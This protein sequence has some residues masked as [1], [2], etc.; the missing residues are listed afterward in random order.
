MAFACFLLIVATHAQDSI[1]QTEDLASAEQR[2]GGY[3]YGGHRGGHYGHYGHHGYRGG[4]RGRRDVESSVDVADQM[5]V[6]QALNQQSEDLFGAEQRYG[7]HHH[8]HMLVRGSRL[9]S[10]HVL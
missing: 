7:G 6:V 1:Q 10:T 3:G 8:H 9:K 2:Y 4:Y 5:P